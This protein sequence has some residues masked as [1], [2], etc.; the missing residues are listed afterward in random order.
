MSTSQHEQLGSWHPALRPNRDLSLVHDGLLEPIAS[1]STLGPSRTSKPYDKEPQRVSESEN[2]GNTHNFLDGSTTPPQAASGDTS[3]VQG[4]P[5]DTLNTTAQ[6][7]ILEPRTSGLSALDKENDE[8]PQNV[9]T[10]LSV[11]K[12]GGVFQEDD[13]F[14]DENRDTDPAWTSESD[15]LRR[16]A[17]RISHTNSF[18]EVPPL[19]TSSDAPPNHPLSHSQVAA[20]LDGTGERE[21]NQGRLEDSKTLS[22]PTQS[23]ELDLF[24]AAGDD[25]SLFV[26]GI[27][28]GDYST[29]LVDEEARFE[30]GLKLISP[31]LSQSPNAAQDVEF[32]NDAAV[33]N[34]DHKDETRDS[35][36]TTLSSTQHDA[37]ST[38][39]RPETLDRKST[40]QVLN[41]LQFSSHDDN[42]DRQHLRGHAEDPMPKTYTGTESDAAQTDSLDSNYFQDQGNTLGAAD[43]IADKEKSIIPEED[44]LTALWQ[45]ALADDDLLEDDAALDNSAFF[46]GDE[47]GF[48]EESESAFADQQSTSF[49]GSN[50]TLQYASGT[51]N[52]DSLSDAAGGTR[53]SHYAPQPQA[54][55]SLTSR[56]SSGFVQQS[57]YASQGLSSSVV[58][59]SGFRNGS[60]QQSPYGIP[61]SF[62][63]PGMPQQTQSFADKSKGGYTSP[64]DIP[65]DVSRPR[66]RAMQQSQTSSG[67]VASGVPPPPPRSTS[68]QF[69]PISPQEQMAFSHRDSPSMPLATN[70]TSTRQGSVFSPPT[71][72]VVRPAAS[73]ASGSFF[74]E[75]PTVSKPRPASSAGRFAP[76]SVQPP[77]Q[78]SVH[79]YTTQAPVTP[80]QFASRRADMDH[81]SAAQQYPPSSTTSQGYQLLPPQRTLPF[82]DS[83]SSEIPTRPIPTVNSRYSPAP[84]SQPNLP[85]NGTRYA[86]PPVTAGPPRPPSVSQILPFQPRTSSPLA[87]SASATHS[88]RQPFHTG[89][90][91]AQV[92]EFPT[93]ARRP[94]LKNSR[95]EPPI[96][97][98]HNPLAVGLQPEDRENGDSGDSRSASFSH[99][100]QQSQVMSPETQFFGTT[101]TSQMLPHNRVANSSGRIDT[102]SRSIPPSQ[103]ASRSIQDLKYLAPSDGQEHD[104]LERWKGCPIINFGFGGNLVMS[105]PKH[106]PRYGT[107]QTFPMIK[108]VPG[109][110]RI[111]SGR[112]LPLDEYVAIFPGPL[113]SKNKKKDVLE[114]L[115]KGIQKLERQ[116]VDAVPY[117]GA[118]DPR[119]RHEEQ[120]ILWKVLHILV[121]FDGVIEGNAL[122]E[123]A[124]RNVL[125]PEVA[126]KG[127]FNEAPY[128]SSTRPRGISRSGISQDAPISTNPE[129]VESLRKILLQ[130]EREKAV[131]CAVDKRLWGHAMII[132]STLPRDIWKQV[133]QEFVRHEVR[134]VGDNTESLAAMY[135]VFAGNWEESV[136]QL[137]PPSARAGL[138]MM[139]KTESL[140][141]SKNALDGLNRWRETLSLI[142]SNRTTDD[143]RALIALGRLLSGYGRIEAA[144]ICYL[145]AK[146]PA[147]FGGPEDAQA[148]IT[149]VGADHLKQPYDYCRD[150]QSIL[151]TEIYEFVFTILA[152]SAV[153]TIAPHLQAHKLYHATILTEY[154]Y[155]E[156]AQQY[157]DAI[158]NALK[159]TTKLSPYYHTQLFGALEDLSNRLRQ[160]PKEGSSSW[161]TKP[162]IDKVSGSVWNKL[163]SFITGDESDAA[164]TGSGH[165]ME[166]EGGPFARVSGDT[167]SISRQPSPNEQYGSYG[168]TTS[169]IPAIPTQS[170]NK[171]R[172]APGGAYT[173]VPGQDPQRLGQIDVLK[174]NDIRKQPSYSS[175]PAT[176]P[177]HLRK[178]L[179]NPYQ[180]VPRPAST[181]EYPLG[182]TRPLPMTSART[183]YSP[184]APVRRSLDQNSQSSTEYRPQILPHAMSLSDEP[185][186]QF[187]YEPASATQEFPASTHGILTSPY[188]PRSASLRQSPSSERSYAPRSASLGPRPGT[189]LPSPVSE[190][191]LPAPPDQRTDSYQP[192]APPDPIS[193]LYEPRS[194]SPQSFSQGPLSSK[195]FS[196]YE[197]PSSEEPSSSYEPP[198]APLEPP[199][200]YSYE[201]SASTYDPPSY[202]PEEQ[203]GELS[204]FDS[205]D[206]KKKSFMD[207]DDED[208]VIARA[209]AL[210]KE[211]KARKDRE[212]DEAFRKAAEADGRSIIPPLVSKSTLTK[213]FFQPKKAPV[214]RLLQNR[215]RGFLRSGA[216]NR[217]IRLRPNQYPSKLAWATNL[218]SSM[219]RTLNAGST[220]KEARTVRQSLQR[221]HHH[222]KAHPIEQSALLQG[223]LEV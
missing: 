97:G 20:I 23:P 166:A 103:S 120:I 83:A 131:W 162:S 67:R 71:S 80:H 147:L 21:S 203:N 119:K 127:P 7:E 13:I 105:F 110:I 214:P 78:P 90:E 180:Q 202:D 174:R 2:P 73:A 181:A 55:A 15:A 38:F 69:R 40:S 157:C 143:S 178:Q 48:L 145:F 59:P 183:S 187:A 212:A 5:T 74:E 79:A 98:L 135:D 160:A 153:S 43:K 87:R 125:S 140:G 42:H 65:V 86:V 29:A 205:K 213:H 8:I 25:E 211:E 114:W 109:E 221:P 91:L 9:G 150:L 6:R 151:L 118:V 164:S 27:A 128:D 184:E 56:H 190:K 35:F 24:G 37:F 207:D 96:G 185:I 154:G 170:P 62:P 102:S 64:Y 136:D 93:S 161:I 123:K 31:D 84:P 1:T 156:E 112:M 195:P 30:E 218:L 49:A 89:T 75:L 175:L 139:S 179:P 196:S 61:N 47:D 14:A 199:T 144:H 22:F 191:P 100:L 107:G 28:S 44:D 126:Q 206:K 34:E 39:S 149:L 19:R 50:G 122:A 104:P 193:S 82:A 63:R 129:A 101:Q 51:E 3:Q 215:P 158:T 146:T 88:Y 81:P 209:A 165:G 52:L 217:K 116:E 70:I 186:P 223:H 113:K 57:S 171:S 16:E 92:N 130:G 192:S 173:P 138:Q 198:S 172:Y 169:H 168:S 208:D 33:H 95:T 45:A 77:V 132:S 155:R 66:K 18:P 85:A 94:S 152:P 197:P 148:S 188:E 68:I 36:F 189:Y 182:A 46:N 220:R 106:I 54:D 10:Q 124:V 177:D 99:P 137:V 194:S 4:L 32:F 159:A 219:I 108:C 76:Q 58:G 141:T 133:I 17:S 167:P 12:S 216:R 210:K 115:G 111:Q 121:E 201:P 204:P 134:T 41:S 72:G 142:L 26:D 11:P 222:R 60:N 53:K 163:N 200:P 176:S 117:Q